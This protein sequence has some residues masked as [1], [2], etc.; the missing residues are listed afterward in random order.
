MSFGAGRGKLES[1]LRGQD[2]DGSVED[3]AGIL[4]GRVV[5][6][7]IENGLDGNCESVSSG[8]DSFG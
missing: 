1:S 3:G 6:L 5:V 4:G 8:V 2:K 7:D